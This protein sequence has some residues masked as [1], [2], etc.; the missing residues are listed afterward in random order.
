MAKPIIAVDI[1]EVLAA[2]AEYI[3]AYSNKHW[4]HSLT[5]DDYTE[6]WAFWGID[7]MDPEFERRADELHAPG[8]VSKYR[9]LPGAKQALRELAER[10]ELIIVTSRR[11][12]VESETRVWLDKNFPGI[13]SRVILTGFWDNVDDPSRHLHSK[14][15]ILQDNGVDYLIDDQ[16]KHCASATRHGIGAVLFGDYASSHSVALP[17]GVTRCKDWEAVRRYFNGIS[18]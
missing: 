10:F 17:D 16:V 2:E 11:K 8:T 1:D 9:V 5:L 12:R 6:H 4:G 18:T 3:I 7:N 14:G 13:F 15:D